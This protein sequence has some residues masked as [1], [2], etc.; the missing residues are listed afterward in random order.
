MKAGVKMTKVECVYSMHGNL[1]YDKYEPNG[2]MT[3]QA[4]SDRQVVSTGHEQQ[5][6][7]GHEQQ[8]RTLIYHFTLS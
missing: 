7:T 8:V 3:R 6:R 1:L 4:V 5:V 2:C